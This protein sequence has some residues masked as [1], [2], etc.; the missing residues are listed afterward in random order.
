MICEG[1]SWL[2]ALDGS[3]GG[4]SAL[5]ANEGA[6]S[7]MLAPRRGLR[8]CHLSLWR[9]ATPAKQDIPPSPSLGDEL[10]D[11]LTCAVCAQ[12][13]KIVEVDRAFDA[14]ACVV[15]GSPALGEPEQ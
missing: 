10:L 1:R 7:S 8:W 6:A 2:E 5:V 14:V 15:V 3:P 9:L 4:G 11:R 12:D 13:L